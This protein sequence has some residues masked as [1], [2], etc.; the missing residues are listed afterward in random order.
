MNSEYS[1]KTI[2]CYGDSNTWGRIPNKDRESKNAR[3]PNILQGLLG[4]DFDVISEGMPGRTLIATDKEKPYLNGLATLP[5]FTKSH[6]PIDCVIIML[7]TNDTKKKY[8]LNAKQIAN[9]LRYFISHLRKEGIS[10]II[11]I[12]PPKIIRPKNGL[13]PEFVN[14]PEISTELPILYEAIS[15]KEGCSYLNSGSIIETSPVDGIHIS[16]ESHSKLALAIK[17]KV[18]SLFS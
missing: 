17:E 1:V 7:G 14:G 16:R 5:I 10:K 6:Y 15:I 4:A 8:G 9:G 18:V 11:V 12:C 2:L 13:Y 3:W